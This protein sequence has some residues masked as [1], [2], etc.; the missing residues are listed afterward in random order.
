MTYKLTDSNVIVSNL[1]NDSKFGSVPNLF[2]VKVH[3]SNKV[4]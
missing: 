3:E 4:M 2:D 1:L